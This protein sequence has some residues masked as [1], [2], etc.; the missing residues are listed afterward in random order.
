M[1]SIIPFRT[2][3][4]PA[5]T[6]GGYNEDDYWIWCGSV[7]RGEDGRYHMFA[8]RWSKDLPFATNWVTNSEVVRAVAKKPE[9]PY[10]FEEVV[11]PSR[12]GFWDATMTHNPTI[13]YHDGVWILFYIGVNI[14]LDGSDSPINR[15]ATQE[16]FARAFL[17]KRTGYATASSILGPWKRCDK[18]IL[19][20]REDH[21][22]KDI[23]SNP[24]PAIRPDGSVVMLYKSTRNRQHFTK[25]A[26]PLLLGAAGADHWSGDYRRLCDEPIRLN[27]KIADIEDPFIWWQDDHFE[28]V[29]KDMTGEISGALYGGI[30][31]WSPDGINW[32]TAEDPLAYTREVLWDNG[33]ISHQ[34]ML[35]RPEILIQNGVPTHLFAATGDGAGGHL[36]MSHTWNMVIP[37]KPVHTC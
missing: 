1:A 8:S 28:G 22:D 30:H 21:W 4:Q 10:R 24:S 25:N 14:E 13:H 15:P 31:I 2:R 27:G 33:I 37:L 17:N 11:L 36:E 19:Q 12:P 5:I 29:V 20:P 9:G 6:G 7:T 3:I 35:E 34:G 18:P 16:D 26:A 23:I 32:Q